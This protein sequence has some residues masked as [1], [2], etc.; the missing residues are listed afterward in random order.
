MLSR[1]QL[2]L[3]AA[4][5]GLATQTTPVRAG[6]RRTHLIEQVDPMIGTGGH[7]HVYPGATTPFGMIQLSPDTDNARWDASSGYY[8]DDKS[9]MGFSH[10]HLSGTGASDGQDLLVVPAIGDVKLKPGTR[11]N[12]LNSYRTAISHDHERA[13][14]GYYSILLPESGIF[15]ELTA[16]ARAGLHRYTFPAGK[17]VH[18]LLDWHHGAQKDK[19]SRSS[20]FL[21]HLEQRGDD[22]IVGTRCVNQWADGRI[23]HFALKVSRPFASLQ[24]YS[25]DEPRPGTRV[26]GDKLKAVLQY[27]ATLNEPLLIKAAVSAVDIDGA[28]KNLETDIPDWNFERVRQSAAQAWE[29]E[30]DRIRIETS[31]AADRKIFY[32]ALYHSFLAPTIFKDS[33]GRYRGM[34]TAVHTLPEGR[35]NY[36][37]YSLWDIYRAWYSMMTILAPDQAADFARNLIDQGEESPYGPVVWPL[38]GR[39]T[40]CMI[41]WH[42]DSIIAEAINKGLPNID[43]QKAWKVYR[44]L[45]FELSTAGLDAYR[46]QGYVP[47]DLE[48]QSVSKTIE[49]CHDDWSMARIADAAGDHAAAEALRHRSKNYRNVFDAEIF[50]A[51]P[52]FKN[53]K[54]AEPFDPRAMGYHPKVWWDYTES[55]SWQATFGVQHDVYGYI[56]QFGGDQAFEARL[57]ALFN[58]SSELPPDAPEDMTGLIGQYV[59]GNEPSHHIAYLYTYCGAAYKTQARVRMLLKTQYRAAP[60]GLSGNEDCGQMSAWYILSALGLYPVDPVS[61]IYVFG[62]PLFPRAEIPLSNGKKLVI[63]AEH[64]DDQHVYIDAVQWNG[65]PHAKTWIAY[66]TLMQ[67]GELR[68]TMARRPNLDFGKAPDARP[69]SFTLA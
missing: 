24:L 60:D 67:G 25:N 27:G 15:C 57:D 48:D 42:S 49:Y 56:A 10:T 65:K 20:V 59:H 35:G 17:D 62:A 13:V 12:G 54:W 50:F 38:Q 47:A 51:R 58:A 39:E 43:V 2:M 11:D 68:F 29:T 1:R 41:G 64:V 37:T 8:I 22:T 6:S 40:H 30:L 36:S 34:D 66:R 33:D 53:G 3:S 5:I 9:L 45:A 32:A 52:R 7:G 44:Y 31:S 23:I 4:A 19:Y 21:A 18:I 61:G 46:K 55:N 16:T 14:P 63:I 26:D 28:L 69:P